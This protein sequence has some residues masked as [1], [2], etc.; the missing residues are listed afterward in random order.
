MSSNNNAD[1]SIGTLFTG[2]QDK[3]DSGDRSSE[4]RIGFERCEKIIGTLSLFSSN[5]E[6]EEVSTA[7]L[8]FLL[9]K[10]YIGQIFFGQNIIRY[11]GASSFD[12]LERRQNVEKAQKYLNEFVHECENYGVN[13]LA[14]DKDDLNVICSRAEFSK[15]DPVKQREIRIRRFKATKD[16]TSRITALKLSK[17]SA[18]EE[19]VRMLYI[20]QLIL[21]L[22]DA[23]E[24]LES[25]FS[26]LELLQNAPSPSRR[27]DDPQSSILDSKGQ[28]SGAR[29]KKNG[30]LLS[31][32]GRPLQPFVITRQDVQTQVFKPDY[33]LPTMTIDQYLEEERK[34]GGILPVQKQQGASNHNTQDEKDSDSDSDDAVD[35]KRAWDEFKDNNPRGSGNRMV[36]RG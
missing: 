22:I 3:Y 8:P 5:E 4:L 11:S 17:N 23:F 7:S 9:T 18:D 32:A 25:I 6:L 13:N 12:P 15:M 10:Y 20:N 16:L 24:T 34:R 2:L 28:P 31:A 21:A 29:V 1:V 36:N 14:K 30:P 35:K 27:L 33:N 26:E 19:N